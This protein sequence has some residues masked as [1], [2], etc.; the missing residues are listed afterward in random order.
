MCLL[1]TKMVK[2]NFILKVNDFSISAL[3]DWILSTC[4]NIHTLRLSMSCK[5]PNNFH[6]EIGHLKKLKELDVRGESA[7]ELKEVTLF[8]LRIMTLLLTQF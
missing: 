7:S 1:V 6:N 3:V 2:I 5:T 8:A 4:L